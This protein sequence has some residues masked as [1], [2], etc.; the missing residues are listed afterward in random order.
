MS[1]ERLEWRRVQQ[2]RVKVNGGVV[3]DRRRGELRHW[4]W[5]FV[6]LGG[7]R[8]HLRSGAKPLVRARD[9]ARPRCHSRGAG[10]GTRE[11][12]PLSSPPTQQTRVS[13]GMSSL[14][15]QEQVGG[16]FRLKRHRRAHKHIS[17]RRSSTEP[18]WACPEDLCEAIVD[19]RP[20]R[21]AGR[22]RAPKA[23][24]HTKAAANSVGSIQ[25]TCSPPTRS[26][27][28]EAR[29]RRSRWSTPTATREP[30]K[31]SSDS[32]N[33]T[34]CRPAR[35]RAA[36][37][38]RSTSSAKK[39]TTHRVKAGNWRPRWTSTWRPPHALHATSCSW[40]RTATSSATSASPSTRRRR[41]ARPRSQTATASPTNSSVRRRTTNS[42]NSTSTTITRAS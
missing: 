10:G 15:V 3:A 41:S 38:R 32:A 29:H 19:P 16:G 33:D 7:R 30:K 2:K 39:R 18:Y 4:Q 8:R 6:K 5:H 34:N 28:R 42:K 22:W 27:R 11:R 13:A 14:L 20:V 25:K 9:P 36:A 26:R 1:A 23:G 17:L 31:I 21:V 37:S 35:K 24:R 40:R 12:A